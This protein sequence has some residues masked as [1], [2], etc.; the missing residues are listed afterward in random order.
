MKALQEVLKAWLRGERPL[1]TGVRHSL[2]G[3]LLYLWR[4]A[5]PSPPLILLPE[6]MGEEVK[7]EIS[8]FQEAVFLPPWDSD[9]SSGI[10]PSNMV[11]AQ[12]M[13]VL[14]QLL[15]QA[16]ILVTT[17]RGLAQKVI[18]PDWFVERILVVIK[19]M[20]IPR[21]ELTK[22]LVDLG[23]Q[24]TDQVE[25]VGGF[26]VRGYVVDVFPLNEDSPIRIELWG[27]E[28]ESIRSFHPQT[29]T[30]FEEREK[31]LILPYRERR[32]EGRVPLPS[33]LG[34][35]PV[36][37]LYPEDVEI[38]REG[39]LLEGDDF[40]TSQEIEAFIG[41]LPTLLVNSLHE[42]GITF[43]VEGFPLAATHLKGTK[44][45]SQGMN[46]VRDRL[47]E[48]LRVYV[49]YPLGEQERML[50][51]FREYDLYPLP[52]P[53][54]SEREG[55]LYIFPSSLR[56]GFLWPQQRIAIVSHRE[57]LGVRRKR[58]RRHVK[59]RGDPLTTLRDLAPGD[60]VVHTEQGI[61]RYIGLKQVNVEG[62]K[63]EFMVIEY[64]GGDQLLVPITRL[65]LIQK[66]RGAHATPPA[67]DKLGGVTWRRTKKR[68][69][70]AVEE[71]AKQLLRI[72][73][74]RRIAQ[75]HAFTPDTSE[76]REF[77]EEFPFDETPDQ[78][79]V[80]REIKEE[81]ESPH[82]M[83]RLLCGDVGY[84]KTEVA[85]RAAFKA[86]LDGKQVAVLVPTTILA[87]QHMETFT[88]RFQHYPVI[89]E[90]ISR[91]KSPREQREI[92][93]RVKKGEVDILIGT[94][95]LLSRDVTFKDLGLV[96]VDEEH[97]FG[98]RQKERLKEFKRGVDVL[99][100][101]ATPIPRTLH[102]ALSGV[103]G[104]SIMETPP[105]GR[106]PVKI[107]ITRWNPSLV[108]G[109]IV[110]ELQRGGRVFVVQPRVEGIEELLELVRRLVPG[111]KVAMAHGQMKAK[112]LEDVMYR[113]MKGKVD[114]LV[115]TPIVESGLDVPFANTLVVKDAH[116]LGLSQL[117]Q[118]RGRVGRGREMGYAYFFIP[119]AASLTEEGKKRLHALREFSQL[120]SGLKLAMRDM[121]IRG[122][123]TILGTQQW[124]HASQVGFT[125][126]CQMLEKTVMKLQGQPLKEEAEPRI[127][128]GV[129]ALIPSTYVGSEKAKIALYKRIAQA[130]CPD[131]LLQLQEE[132]RD[133]FGP[134]PKP[135]R[136]LFTLASI[137]LLL[138]K[139]GGERLV[140]GKEGIFLH[141]SPST[142]LA[143]DGLSHLVRQ[144]GMRTLGEYTLVIPLNGE[145]LREVE[146]MLKELSEG[147]T[148][149]KT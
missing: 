10:P 52:L 19:G 71:F 8:A 45:V 60:Y 105:Q 3:Y 140:K 115:S 127:E 149:S 128:L 100:L 7:D 117:Y 148:L 133:R 113:F 137:R 4:D 118:L 80:C 35:R 121:E 74:E 12:R 67:L 20:E 89:I 14:L 124:G 125:L 114:V 27:D 32:G 119:H 26:S 55:A 106:R 33:I 136:N 82:P 126:Y 29:Q 79:K 83:D 31:A 56:E 13:Q 65:H 85:M 37:V 70:K 144:K 95:R 6:E 48:G 69:K 131:E 54:F 99:S 97:R 104:M 21:E 40:L 25:E 46:W 24:W 58:A 143:Q 132:M 36:V 64:D 39:L 102:M 41:S 92:L 2:L 34:A 142:P 103:K 107:Q 38:E 63:Q 73:A 91:F 120:G 90:V 1:L 141:L 11:S 81:M 93:D 9:P 66:Y 53:R 138:K 15:E 76:Q 43:P 17:V 28:V 78:E 145:D 68:V 139:L 146:G 61:G 44:R 129:E 108:R 135:V 84:G 57:L 62:I 77:E 130:G 147:V 116:I 134:F 101:S 87:E 111:A 50:Q 23:Y 123:G 96:I 5:L 22:R 86:V 47:S 18:E 59:S 112:E 51:L 88:E 30:S 49:S 16:P 110:K 75:G 94:H 122:A 42:E 98:V 72:E 109:A